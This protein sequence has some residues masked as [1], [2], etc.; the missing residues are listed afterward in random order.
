MRISTLDVFNLANNSISDANSAIAKTQ[1][2]LSTGR[3]VLTAADDPVAAIRIQNL[4]ENIA[5][6]DQYNKNI[7]FTQSNLETEEAALNSV[8][9]LVQR[10]RELAVQ[11]GNTS[12]LSNSE[13]EAI[14]TEVDSRLDELVSLAN[15]RNSNGDYIFAGYKSQTPAFSGDSLNG[16]RFDGDEGGISIKVDNNTFVD[17]SDSGKSIFVDIPSSEN[18]VTTASNP[19][20]RSVPPISISIGE[21]VDQAAYDEFYPEDIAITFSDD[22]HLTPA[23]KNFTV[24]ER[25]TGKIIAQNQPYVAGEELVY[26]GVSVT[27]SGTPASADSGAGVNGD[28]LFVNSTST[29]DVLT[30]IMRFR[31]ALQSFDGSTESRERISNSVATTLD[32]ITHVQSAVSKVVTTIGARLNILESTENQHLDTTLVSNTILGDIRDLDY[33]EAA[34]R[35]SAQTLILQ[36]AQASFL[37]ISELTLFSRL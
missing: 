31:D 2:Q 33:A 4:T 24:T 29:Q 13:Y 1:E 15:T 20:N 30:T 23:A 28:Q 32:N 36:A 9:N 21:V 26:H 17:A 11:A 18:T 10:I 37:R 12:S 27:I 7:A 5:L 3:R 35:L 6:I 34:S 8:D 19:N 16:F 22:S 25:S 14:A